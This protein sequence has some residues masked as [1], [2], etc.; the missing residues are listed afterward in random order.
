M[1]P[2]LTRTINLNAKF[3]GILHLLPFNLDAPQENVRENDE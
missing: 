1:L 2:L 3:P